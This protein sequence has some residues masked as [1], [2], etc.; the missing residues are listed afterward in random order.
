MQAEEITVGMMVQHDRLVTDVVSAP[1][2]FNGRPCVLLRGVKEPVP[3][4]NLHDATEL[5]KHLK[6][7]KQ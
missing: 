1:R 3:V 6:E 4:A 7:T 2:D 5:V